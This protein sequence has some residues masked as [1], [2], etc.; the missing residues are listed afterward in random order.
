LKD[1]R[2]FLLGVSLHDLP[3][4]FNGLA[5]STIAFDICMLLPVL[6]VYVLAPAYGS[7]YLIRVEHRHPLLR[8][9]FMEPFL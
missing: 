1:P 7:L 3:K 2:E 4:A 6:Q 8:D 5:P 9:D